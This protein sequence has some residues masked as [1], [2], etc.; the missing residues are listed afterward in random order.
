MT[1]Q[2]AVTKVELQSMI[3]SS[4]VGGT[5]NDKNAGSGASGFSRQSGSVWDDDDE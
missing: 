4:P 2:T 5:V 1:P 3:A